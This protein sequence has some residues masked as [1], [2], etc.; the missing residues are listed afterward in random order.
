MA[1]CIVSPTLSSSGAAKVRISS[2][3]SINSA[4]LMS[5]KKL[6]KTQKTQEKGIMIKVQASKMLMRKMLA[7]ILK[8]LANLLKIS[9]EMAPH[10]KV[11]R[12]MYI[13]H[14]ILIILLT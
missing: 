9:S 4:K 12:I 3:I 7:K 11:R 14:S 10:L 13:H 2:V 5:H 6:I 1:E 8:P